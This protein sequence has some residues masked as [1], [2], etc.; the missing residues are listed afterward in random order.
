[1]F[2][3]IHALTRDEDTIARITEEVTLNYMVLFFAQSAQMV[4][5]FADEN[6]MYFAC[7]S[8]L[9]LTRATIDIW[10]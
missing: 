4:E 9:F 1:M 7:S 2:S 5:D 6:T 8:S 10:K 3:L